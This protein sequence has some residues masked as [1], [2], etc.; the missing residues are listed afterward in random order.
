L[1]GFRDRLKIAFRVKC[2]FSGF[3][4]WAN[5][6]LDFQKGMAWLFIRV[7]KLLFKK[8]K[9]KLALYHI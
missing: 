7:T 3:N 2:G 4:L 6:P 5:S 8:K 1:D 9:A